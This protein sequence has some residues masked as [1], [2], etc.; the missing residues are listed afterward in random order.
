MAPT[1]HLSPY[2]PTGAKGTGTLSC[3]EW[4][5]EFTGRTWSPGPHSTNQE[6][7]EKRFPKQWSRYR[8]QPQVPSTQTK[9]FS[10]SRW[11]TPFP[12]IKGAGEAAAARL[13][14][15]MGGDNSHKYTIFPR[16]L[17]RKPK[18]LDRG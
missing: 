9:G 16:Y 18:C 7:E 6:G 10:L 1:C 8:S 17:G 11:G 14:W 5:G 4:L 13:H 2:G 3:P 12:P 15:V